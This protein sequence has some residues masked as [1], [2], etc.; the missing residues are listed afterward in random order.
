MLNWLQSFTLSERLKGVFLLAVTAVLLSTSGIGIKWIDWNPLAIAGARS[1][2]AALVIWAAFRHSP[3]SWN[4]ASVIG[5]VAYAAMMLTFVTAIKLTT[6]ANAILLQYTCPVYVAI[7]GAVFLNE[8]PGWRDLATIGAVAGGMVLFFQEQM[9]ADGLAGNLLAI[10]SGVSMA[11]MTVA[12][13]LQKAGSPFGSVLLG[14]GLTF[15]CGLPFLFSGSPGAGGWAA[16]VA[17]GCVQIG[18]AYVLYSIAI[19]YVTALEASIITMIEPI[20]NPLWVFLLLG[21]GPGFWSLVG[22]GIILLA[23]AARYIVPAIKP[24][25]AAGS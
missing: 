14:N 21:E 25:A 16:I 23:I 5:G 9:S 15:L 10:L 13:R 3:V 20:L 2:V 8:R 19:K 11:V 7:L 18:L 1:G 6:A 12:M 24:G 17:L 22:G 4:K